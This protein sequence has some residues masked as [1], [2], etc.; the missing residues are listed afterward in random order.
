MSTVLFPLGEPLRQ[1]VRLTN[2]SL[3]NKQRKIAKMF[4]IWTIRD[5]KTRITLYNNA[6]QA[7]AYYMPSNIVKTLSKRR[8]PGD[9]NANT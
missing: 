2:N 8:R 7:V 3:N 9:W 4:S 6:Q 5:I 1:L